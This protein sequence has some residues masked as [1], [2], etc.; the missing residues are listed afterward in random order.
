MWQLDIICVDPV[1][2][3]GW[4]HPTGRYADEPFQCWLWRTSVGEAYDV[5]FFL[6]LL[7]F[8][9]VII[10]FVIMLEWAVS[11]VRFIKATSKSAK[12]V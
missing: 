4:S 1:W 12:D 5:L 10:V 9:G 7:S 2:A 8:Y 6:N 11:T 3:P